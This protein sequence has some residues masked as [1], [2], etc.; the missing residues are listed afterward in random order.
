MDKINRRAVDAIEE[1]A[2]RNGVRVSKEYRKL[3]MSPNVWHS[4]K[5]LKYAPSAYFLR[6]MALAGYD[7]LYILTGVK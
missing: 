5:Y 4:W 7:V 6:Q 2:Q 3:D 1:R